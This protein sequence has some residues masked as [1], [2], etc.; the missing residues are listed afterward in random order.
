[1]KAKTKIISAAALSTLIIFSTIEHTTVNDKQLFLEPTKKTELKEEVKIEAAEDTATETFSQTKETKVEEKVNNT[2]SI[3]LL[4]VPF[5]SQ[6]PFGEWSDKRQQDGCEETSAL[7]AVFWAR[8][9]ELSRE[10]AK[11]EIL[12]IAEYEKNKYGGFV[13]TNAKDT[14]ERIIRGYFNYEKAKTVANIT[15]DNIKAELYQGNLVLVPCNGRK[16]G[17]PN[18]TPPGPE[19][20]MLVIR[21]YDPIKKEFITNDA[22]TRKGEKYRYKEEILYKA[23]VDYPTGDHEPIVEDIKSMVVVWK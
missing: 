6:A 16:L 5:T 1:M 2:S 8:G 14:L 13:D 11:K 17:N 23:I 20:H 22:G 12:A 7:M 15:I 10:N 21:G 19:R 4:D 3:S 18:Y 9:E